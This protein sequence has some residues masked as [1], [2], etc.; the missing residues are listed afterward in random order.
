[1]IALANSGRYAEVEAWAAPRA[2]EG[3][4]DAQFLMGF[5]VYAGAPI[6]FATACDWLRRAAAQGHAE[7]LYR[8]AQI[9]ESEPRVHSRSPINDTMRATLRRA[10]E[11][12]SADAQHDLAILLAT[13]HGG[14]SR[15]EVEARAWQ[16]RAARAEHLRAQV[17]FG[18]MCLQGKGGPVAVPEGL[19]WLEKAA[20]TAIRSDPWAPLVVSQAAELLEHTYTA[21]A[22]P[23]PVRATAAHDRFVAAQRALER[24]EVADD[25][26]FGHD[27]QGR[28]VTRPFAFADRDE[29]RRTLAEHMTA[30]RERG[31]AALLADLDRDV[32][33]RLRGASGTEYEVSMRVFWDDQP[34]GAI[35]VAGS[36]EEVG[37]RTVTTL[38][39]FFSVSPDGIIGD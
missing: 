23:D 20:S 37:W 5:L 10:A 3:E 39:E 14:F 11:L 1:M 6:D 33:T 34:E 2:E 19:A 24:D 18:R 17:S 9:D 13:G 27:A 21:G 22:A 35:S 28:S 25:R 30:Q 8:L 15:D 26:A 38:S 12:G 29:A 4:A 16:E 36:I 7:A 31:R 32:V